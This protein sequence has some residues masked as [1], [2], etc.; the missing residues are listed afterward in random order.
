M[1]VQPQLA[2]TEQPSERAAVE[3][4]I[5]TDDSRAQHVSVARCR[6]PLH[7]EDH[8]GAVKLLPTRNPEIPLLAYRI[9]A[10]SLNVDEYLIVLNNDRVC[11]NRFHRRQSRHATGPCIEE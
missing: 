11:R 1:H 6:A 3:H 2:T 8:Y 9:Y 4:I 7:R 10:G 5:D